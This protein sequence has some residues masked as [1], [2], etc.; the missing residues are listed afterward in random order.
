MDTSSISTQSLTARTH[1]EALV[2]RRAEPPSAVAFDGV[3]RSYGNVRA[4]D[5]VDLTIPI[6]S[7]VALLGPN[8]AGKSTALGLMLG[9]LH[10]DPGS[11]GVL[12]RA[13]RDAVEAGR[14][15]AMLQVGGLPIGVTVGEIVDFARRL[16]PRPM[17]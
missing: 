13:P 2:D 12:G 17:T 6:G 8:G 5:A 11:V 9:L 15:G 16:Y 14:V 1:A 3:S 10:P 4:L 7:T